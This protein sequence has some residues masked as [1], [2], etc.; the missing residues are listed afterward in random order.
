MLWL[1][2]ASSRG[3]C[4]PGPDRFFIARRFNVLHDRIEQLVAHVS[5]VEAGWPGRVACVEAPPAFGGIDIED[6]QH[7]VGACGLGD[8]LDPRAVRRRVACEVE[9]D[10]YAEREQ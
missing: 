4:A 1:D 5:E 10:G 6:V 2:S 3:G 9:H 7:V 8:R